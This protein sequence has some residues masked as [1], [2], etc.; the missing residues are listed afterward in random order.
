MQVGCQRQ[1]AA[2]LT[3]NR[4]VEAASDLVVERAARGFGYPK[5]IVQ[6]ALEAAQ[7]LARP[8]H[9][10]VSPKGRIKPLPHEMGMRPYGNGASIGTVPAAGRS[11]LLGAK[12]SADRRNS[13]RSPKPLGACPAHYGTQA[14]EEVH[15]PVRQRS[16]PSPRKSLVIRRP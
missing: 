9:N 15:D 5:D 4:R 11:R 7:T 12:I 1:V 8:C 3:Y 16:S 10:H 6:R 14:R 2:N 13:I